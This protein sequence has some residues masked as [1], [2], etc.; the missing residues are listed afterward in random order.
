MKSDSIQF[1]P[2]PLLVG[3]L[4]FGG[5]LAFA[6]FALSLCLAFLITLA[7]WI[8]D[9][10]VSFPLTLVFAGC[11]GGMVFSIAM[12]IPRTWSHIRW[13]RET[14]EIAQ[15]RQYEIE[16]L[17][18]TPPTP[19]LPPAPALP[20][21]DI[22][23]TLVSG[24]EVDIPRETIHGMEPVDVEWLATYLANGNKFTEAALEK[25]PLI[26]NPKERWGKAEGAT[27]YN[28]MFNAESGI[29]IQAGVIAGRG[30]A[31]NPSGKLVET[32]AREIVRKVR[33][34]PVEE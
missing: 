29:L 22:H 27:P 16:I 1:N 11:G 26:S 4:K 13:E 20:Q 6:F 15:D 33:S 12:I 9:S 8:A 2:T 10:D 32:D 28:R 17:R 19:A 21:P 24:R 5:A 18:F 23:A 3:E 7:G 31:G 34:L 30:G 14:R 25:M